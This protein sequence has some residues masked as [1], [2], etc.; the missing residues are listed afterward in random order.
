MMRLQLVVVAAA[1]SLC[2][3]QPPPPG[4]QH[5]FVY[6]RT[7]GPMM[8]GNRIAPIKG[9]PYTADVTTESIQTLGDGN[10]IVNRSTTSVARD[11][12]G[13]TR[14]EMNIGMIGSAAVDG[15]PPKMIMLHD[16][17]AQVTYTLDSNSKTA[18]KV[19]TGSGDMMTMKLGAEKLVAEKTM[20]REAIFAGTPTAGTAVA[21]IS[22]AGVSVAGVPPSGDEKPAIEKKMK[23]I[24]EAGMSVRVGDR[25]ATTS[26]VE[27]L[28]TQVIEGVVA[29]GT[30]TTET[31]PAGEIGNEK[32]L[33][34]VNEVWIA[35]DLRAVILS[36]RTDPRM[37]E[38][39]YKLTNIQ[40]SEPPASLFEVPAGYK[41]VDAPGP[42]TYVIT[43]KE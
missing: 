25:V 26:K 6:N 2:A 16:P 40:R 23:Y 39:T 38:T 42:G 14:N 34:I 30:R 4:P 31:I 41:I 28:G 5:T 9:A 32:D 36:K 27:N 20:H 35:Q 19:S 1:S 13:R 21:G 11:S 10:R 18:N 7:A 33:L 3:Q 29:E 37:G 43:S 22:V 8:E 12:Q 15:K 24:A 17:V